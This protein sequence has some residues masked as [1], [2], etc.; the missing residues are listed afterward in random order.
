MV[1]LD[2]REKLRARIAEA[3][4]PRLEN[5]EQLAR[6]LKTAGVKLTRQAIYR[7]INGE[8]ETLKF[9][10]AVALEKLTTYRA[11]WI[12][13]GVGPKKNK[14]DPTPVPMQPHEFNDDE[15]NLF[16]NYVGLPKDA[17]QAVAI[18]ISTLTAAHREKFR[19]WA[20]EQRLPSAVRKLED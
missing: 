6:D 15:L 7:W 13:K 9:D 10:T 4:G 11:E 18:L 12:T 16:R 20:R 17:R 2:K 3:C 1:D 5:A 19:T 8:V 14:G